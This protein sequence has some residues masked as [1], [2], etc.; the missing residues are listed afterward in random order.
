MLTNSTFK[1][2]HLPRGTQRCEQGAASASLIVSVSSKP[3]WCAVF[4][5]QPD[6]GDRGTAHHSRRGFQ[7]SPTTPAAFAL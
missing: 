4:S 3:R 6:T 1:A 2:R 5:S 7:P